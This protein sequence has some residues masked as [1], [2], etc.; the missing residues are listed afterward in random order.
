M[1]WSNT[2]IFDYILRQFALI[3][4]VGV[5]TNPSSLILALIGTATFL[6]FGPGRRQLARR[7]Y[8][9]NQTSTAQGS[10]DKQRA[11]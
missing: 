10:K 2:T 1:D 4:E 11:A 3:A 5:P 9:Q 8:T 7:R 6:I